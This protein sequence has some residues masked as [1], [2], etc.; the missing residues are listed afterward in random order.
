M[1]YFGIYN[2]CANLTEG[3]ILSA[4]FI[5][6]FGGY[7]LNSFSSHRLTA[8][9]TFRYPNEYG[10]QRADTFTTTVTGA[11]SVIL[12]SIP[13]NIRIAKATIG[14]VID[15]DFTDPQDMGRAMAPACYYTIKRH[16][17]DF[18]LTIDDY[19]LIITGD[20]SKYGYSLLKDLFLEEKINIQ[21]KV[22]DSG[23]LIYQKS[24]DVK[25][26]GSGC[27]CIGV[28]LSYIIRLL[29]TGRLNKVL[30]VATG[31]LMTPC[32][33]AQKESI[34]TIAHAISLEVE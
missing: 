16:L 33:L 3:M 2:A 34:P 8:E 5:E 1:P 10:M 25:A 7:A 15:G 17:L 29:T 11:G 22:V 24:Q 4:F 19:D 30:L 32:M 13:K 31:A 26:G 9:R 28:V 12:T 27:G 14:K 6:T 20:L 23:M 18:N 21:G